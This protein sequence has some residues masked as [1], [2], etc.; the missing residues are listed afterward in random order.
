MMLVGIL[1]SVGV[2]SLFYLVFLF[3]CLLIHM[4]A[5]QPRKYIRGIWPVLVFFAALML[6]VRYLYQFTDI[7]DPIKKRF[8]K[9]KYITLQDLSLETFPQGELFWNLLGN[10]IVLVM[11]VIQL[12]FFRRARGEK[13]APFDT[14]TNWRK[15]QHQLVKFVRR[16]L[17]L[18]A[19][20]FTMLCA[21]L[22][23]AVRPSMLN[24][25]VLLFIV[26]TFSLH[27]G[28]DHVG[29]LLLLYTEAV[30]LAQYVFR[31]SFF[32][33]TQW[34]TWIGLRDNDSYFHVVKGYALLLF[35]VLL[36]RYAARWERKHYRHKPCYLF[37]LP[38]SGLMLPEVADDNY[39]PAP[40][41]SESTTNPVLSE[42]IQR[43]CK[44]CFH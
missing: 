9:N 8:P 21:F 26:G 11:S 44:E 2:I 3:V 23:C 39:S 15:R 5:K 12:N 1:S 29:V 17:I 6:L 22:I 42:T 41:P 25:V 37:G 32:N 10:T 24:V 36:Q 16:L 35:F 28:S 19:N 38:K 43:K 31:F 18:H 30:M 14:S 7:S 4:T 20:K 27:R 13:P 34:T 33:D 40:P